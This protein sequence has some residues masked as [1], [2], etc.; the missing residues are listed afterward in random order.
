V[1]S[2]PVKRCRLLLA[3]GTTVCPMPFGGGFAVDRARLRAQEIGAGLTALLIGAPLDAETD[4]GA[5]TARLIAQIEAGVRDGWL[6]EVPVREG[7]A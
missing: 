5:G 3:A 7:A 2:D 1:T 4:D 6:V